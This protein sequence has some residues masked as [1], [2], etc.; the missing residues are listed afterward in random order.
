M[1]AN[2]ISDSQD[3][4]SRLDEPKVR[5]LGAPSGRDVSLLELSALQASMGHD[6]RLHVHVL[7]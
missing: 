7:V 6:L 4:D 5:V 1:A 3:L 2:V